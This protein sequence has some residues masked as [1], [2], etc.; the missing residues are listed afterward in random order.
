M[1]ERK[2]VADKL[3]EYEVHRFISINLA[4]KAGH[5]ATKIQRTPLGEKITIFASKP[6]LI[7]GKKGTNIKNVTDQLKRKFGF[8]NPQIEIS[9]VENPATNAKIVAENIASTLERFG[10][11][12]F[13]GIGHKA[14][15]AAI[16]E[17]VLGIEILISGRIPSARAKTWRFYTGYLKKCGD[18]AL[19]GVDTAY[20]VAKLKT[21][22][23]GI[24]VRIM[25]AKTKLPDRIELREEPLEIIEEI[26]EEKIEKKTTKVKKKKPKKKKTAKKK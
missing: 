10:S 13:K 14:M 7:V 1:I 9:E 6:G 17:G 5:S 16:N 21:G 2:I 24:Q 18:I 11:Q 25:P 3:R 22:V 26:E 12:R 20:A 23:V 8:E 19:T 15:E 4:S